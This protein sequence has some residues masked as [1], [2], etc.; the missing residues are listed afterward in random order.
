M[1]FRLIQIGLILTLI[2]SCSEERKGRVLYL[3]HNL[4]QTHPVHKGILHL[5]SSLEDVSGGKMTVRIFPDGQ[6]GS[7]R[8][9]LELLQIGSI[10]VT[11]VSAATLSNFVPE[12]HVLGIPYIF[13]DEAHKFRVLEGEIGQSILEKGSRYLLRGLCYYD[14]GSRSFFTRT[15]AIRTPQ[16][17]KGMKIRVMNNQMSVNMV[18]ALGGSGTP[19]AYSELYT[20]I[21]QGVVDGAENN[22]PSFVKSNQYE[23]CKYY[24]LDEHSAVPDVLVISSNYWD[25]LSDE[26]KEWLELAARESAEQ[27]K[28]FWRESVEESMQIIREHGIE[29]IHPDKS[30]FA[31]K[32]TAVSRDFLEEF[33]EM[34]E[35]VKQ[36]KSQ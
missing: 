15:R 3:A 6:L 12:Y 2:L 20:A 4:P 18:N 10:A 35:L 34:K 5:K 28:I 9:V 27:Q 33:P 14:A 19:M 17:L 23:V 1:K 30:L 8:E 24:T 32:T 11:K 13:R 26:E 25:R 29:I 21:Q 36:I 31:E 7:E 16:D 22:A